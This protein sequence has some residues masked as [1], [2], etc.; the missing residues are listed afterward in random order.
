MRFKTAKENLHFCFFYAPGSHHP[1]QLRV[2]FYDIFTTKFKEFAAEGKVY[3]IGDTNARL[4]IA[5]N[6]RNYKDQ[7]IT[8]SNKALLTEFLEYSGLVILNKVYCFAQPPDEIP[9][10]RRSIIDFV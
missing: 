2:Q 3:L 4:G 7:L 1:L 6:D 9:N 8:N 5:L 10:K